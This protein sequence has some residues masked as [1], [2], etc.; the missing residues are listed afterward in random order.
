MGAL[1]ASIIIIFI[2]ARTRDRSPGAV[3]LFRRARSVI[4]FIKIHVCSADRKIRP[5][6]S[7]PCSVARG[8]SY[9]LLL[10][11]FLLHVCGVTRQQYTCIDNTTAAVATQITRARRAGII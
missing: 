10:L 7:S 4:W 8:S 1:F 2:F 6:V 5:A 9:Y 3:V 11:L